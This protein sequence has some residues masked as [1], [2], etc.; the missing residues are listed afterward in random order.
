MPSL[1]DAT[2]QGLLQVGALAADSKTSFMRKGTGVL[3]YDD[4]GIV[5]QQALLR[6][7]SDLSS[8]LGAD[9]VMNANGDG[10]RRLGFTQ[11]AL[12]WKPLSAA[13]VRLK[14]RVGLFYPRM[15]SENA[16][17]GW[18]SPYS[19]TPSAV[20]SWIG[21]ELR[22]LG[23]E[24]SM[25]S[26]G[27]SRR[28]TWS[29]EATAG[30]FGG[31]DPTGTLVGWRGFALTDRQTLYDDRVEFAPIPTIIDRDQLWSKS[32][33][34]PFKEI[35]DRIGHYI[36]GHLRWRNRTDLRLYYYDNNA[37]SS[38]LN[39]DRLYAWDTMF[40]SLSLRHDLT[41]T[42]R[43]LVQWI[44]GSSGMGPDL[45]EIEFDSYYALVSQRIGTSRFSLRYDRWRVSD[46]DSFEA[47]PN[48]SDGDAITLAWRRDMNSSWQFGLEY[49]HND[50]VATNRI[51][52]GNPSGSRQ[53]QMMAVARYRFSL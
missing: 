50:N 1:G 48:D 21:E 37:D 2:L 10:D 53:Q 36:G 25:F 40:G 52:L 39:E 49:I 19:Y 18:L 20:N 9:I 22:I 44:R 13:P 12:K 27:R 11:V 43:L 24:V 5:L 35:D 14:G 38:R 3:R 23:G 6:F 51:T 41:P 29:W 7:S 45:V 30:V 28:S 46:T 8:S 32:W 16:D 15:S 33:V 31:N 34:E 42:I 17:L 47:D 26:P 4:S